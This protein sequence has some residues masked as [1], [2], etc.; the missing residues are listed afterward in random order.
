[1]S[2]TRWPVAPPACPWTGSSIT[3][4]RITEPR[5]S[6]AVR[7]PRP[8]PIVTLSGWNVARQAIPA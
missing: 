5:T 8:A 2:R 1:M 3:T 6:A 4:G 7:S